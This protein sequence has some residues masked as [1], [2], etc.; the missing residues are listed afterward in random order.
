[1]NEL[2]ISADSIVDGKYDIQLDQTVDA[3]IFALGNALK[4]TADKVSNYMNYINALAYRDALTGVK[5]VAAYNEM[6]VDIERRM[7]NGE[8][9][10]F[11]ILVADINMLKLTNDLFGHE[12]GN[13]LIVNAAKIICTVFKHSPVFR[14]GGDEFV[15]LLENSDLENVDSLVELLDSNCSNAFVSADERN[16]PISIARGLAVYSPD[17]HISYADI[18][19][20]ADR[21]MYAH[22]SKAK[23]ELEKKIAELKN[24]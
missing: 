8:K 18:F 19:D 15:V 6:I 22:K 10:N 9:L 23:C 5:N 20:R 2:A 11:A 17:F 16:I 12:M 3:E 1:L 14:I 21:E 4:K 7:R 13:Q 24:G